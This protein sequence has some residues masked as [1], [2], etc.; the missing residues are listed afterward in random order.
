M[1]LHSFSRNRCT[2]VAKLPAWAQ[3]FVGE[4]RVEG[5]WWLG[6]GGESEREGWRSQA[7][8]TLTLPSPSSASE[9]E[10]IRRPCR[11][12]LLTSAAI[13]AV[14]II[15]TPPNLPNHH[16][17]PPSPTHSANSTLPSNYTDVAC[18]GDAFLL[19]QHDQRPP[20][21]PTSASTISKTTREGYE[22]GALP[23][24]P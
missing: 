4:D 5:W 22:T 16:P 14:L 7:P 12:A 17:P 18:P 24:S 21:Q 15:L 3:P 6:C 11:H 10:N 23:P 2:R 9:R 8:S 13:H 1:T 19:H 20:P